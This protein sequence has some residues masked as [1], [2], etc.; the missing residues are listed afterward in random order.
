MDKR[1][2]YLLMVVSVATA[3]LAAPAIAG[4]ADSGLAEVHLVRVKT[5]EKRFFY[6][7]EETTGCP[8]L[9][10]RCRR[11][12]YVLAGDVL[13]AWSSR[14]AF[15]EV[16]FVTAKGQHSSGAIET[17]ALEA[18]AEPPSPS[19]SRS[20][21]IGQWTRDSEA[22]LTIE[23]IGKTGSLRVKGFALWGSS[24]PVRVRN[25]GVNTGE[26]DGYFVP[27]GA[28]GGVLENGTEQLDWRR[29]FP[30]NAEDDYA[31]Q[32]QFRLLGPYLIVYDDGGHCGGVNV[33]FSG[34]YRKG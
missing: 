23:A 20:A 9:T 4:D 25:G 22:H 24:D 14:G 11:K 28:W 8:A 13:L 29:G 32:A 18:V 31:C 27:S 3:G 33:T 10:A 2:A 7:T 12:G 1:I 19:P 21:W 34:I 5:G 6:R 17:A 15:T 16:E 30:F 26:L